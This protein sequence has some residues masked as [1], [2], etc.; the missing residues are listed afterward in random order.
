MAKPYKP[1]EEVCSPWK[2]VSALVIR[3]A[4]QPEGIPNSG[5]HKTINDD[6]QAKIREG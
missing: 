1:R 3:N 4:V 6:R 2:P 5:Q